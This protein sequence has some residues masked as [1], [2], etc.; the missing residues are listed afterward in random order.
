MADKIS[1]TEEEFLDDFG[2]AF[3]LGDKVMEMAERVLLAHKCAP[4]A[5]AVWGFDL[6]GTHYSVTLKVTEHSDG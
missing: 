4:G 6:D 2:A 5:Q 1:V 3:R